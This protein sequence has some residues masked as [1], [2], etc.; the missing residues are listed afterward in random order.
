MK[1]TNEQ[2][3]E[4]IDKICEGISQGLSLR[5]SVK[6]N[7]KINR[8]TFFDWIKENSE[9]ANLY[10]RA[11]EER[12]ELLF[13][14][15]LNIADN[16]NEDVRMTDDGIEVTNHDAIQRSKLRV[17]ARKWILAKMNPKKFGDKNETTLVGDSE[18]PILINLGSGINPNE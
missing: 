8:S 9:L 5:K 3:K 17:D 16:N 6:I 12:Q 14:D 4:I 10:A 2:K 11:C 15:I 18:K 7:S 1:N 13:E